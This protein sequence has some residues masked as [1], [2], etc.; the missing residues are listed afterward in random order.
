M[1]RADE[2][3]ELRPPDATELAPT[4]HSNS[5]GVQPE[6]TRTCIKRCCSG[7]MIFVDMLEDLVRDRCVTTFVIMFLLTMIVFS[8]NLLPFDKSMPY[9]E[10]L[11]FAA[12][13]Q[14]SLTV[15][16][17][18]GRTPRLQAFMSDASLP[19][20]CSD[21]NSQACPKI[22]ATIADIVTINNEYSLDCSFRHLDDVKGT[23]EG[24]R[25]HE[26]CSA[27]VEN[28][29]ATTDSKGLATF[30]DFTIR[31]PEGKYVL[32]F[33]VDNALIAF[34][35]EMA[36]PVV[37]MF[38]SAGSLTYDNMHFDVGVPLPVQP[39]IMVRSLVSSSQNESELLCIEFNQLAATFAL[40]LTSLLA[41]PIPRLLAL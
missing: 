8:G 13:P 37:A 20:S 36:S 10:R 32:N 33:A 26:V 39:T 3:V 41:R 2:D 12:P 19:R 28:G 34:T 23:L 1:A 6:D 30:T 21:L 31:G 38:L 29:I 27:S 17:P 40:L 5:A 4:G 9:V 22:T 14:Y 35:V 25:L 18:S 11:S 7:H 16:I 24:D 15:G